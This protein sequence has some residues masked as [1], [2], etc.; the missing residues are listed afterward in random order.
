MKLY[1]INIYE[2]YRADEKGIYWVDELT[3]D[4]IYYKHEVLEELEVED[5]AKPYAI[6]TDENGKPFVETADN[7]LCLNMKTLKWEQ[8]Q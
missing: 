5:L 6:H 4:T 2:A 1:K 7:I 8:M 3:D